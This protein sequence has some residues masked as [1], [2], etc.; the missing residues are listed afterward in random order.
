MAYDEYII[1]AKKLKKGNQKF[2]IDSVTRKD[3]KTYKERTDLPDR[4]NF[5]GDN[6]PDDY[7]DCIYLGGAEGNRCRWVWGRWW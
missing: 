4:P 7:I 3:G 5:D 2:V 1:E 6:P